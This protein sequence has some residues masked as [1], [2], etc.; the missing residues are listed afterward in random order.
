MNKSITHKIISLWTVV[1]LLLPMLVQFGHTLENHE[2]K[3]CD[4]HDIQHIN[5]QKLDCSFLHVF[6]D[7]T[8]AFIHNSNVTKIHFTATKKPVFIANLINDIAL[9]YKPTRAPPVFIA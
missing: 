1:F 9:L 3:I 6:S 5:K 2:H 8:T 4:S 7:L